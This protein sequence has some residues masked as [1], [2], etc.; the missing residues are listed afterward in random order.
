M[1]K[2][3][4]EKVVEFVFGK[5]GMGAIFLVAV[6]YLYAQM[7]D[8]QQRGEEK[9]SETLKLSENRFEELL[10]EERKYRYD[11]MKAIE[12]CYR[13]NGRKR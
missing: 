8:M 6:I 5:V 10:R 4:T 13:E 9:W 7:Q 1:E 3:F 11:C 12:S 2:S